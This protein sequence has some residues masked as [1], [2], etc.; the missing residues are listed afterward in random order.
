MKYLIIL[1]LFFLPLVISAQSPSS[2]VVHTV[3]AD[4]IVGRYMADYGGVDTTSFVLY[5]KS[6]YY[7]FG[8]G[9]VVLKSERCDTPIS[10]TITKLKI[11]KNTASVKVLFSEGKRYYTKVRLKR[12]NPMSPW[13]VKTRI[14]YP[15]LSIPRK[16]PLIMHYSLNI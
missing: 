6:G 10:G 16:E 2:R 15:I 5:G 12:F 4:S 7:S 9:N 14:I 3:L 13:R 1:H 8:E 11:R